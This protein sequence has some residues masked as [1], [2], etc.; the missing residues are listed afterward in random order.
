MTRVLVVDDEESVR[1]LLRVAFELAGFE[2]AEAPNGAAACE[3]ISSEPAPALVATDYMMPVMDGGELIQRL[4]TDPA[5]A[6]VPVMLISSSPGA[7]ERIGLADAFVQKPFDPTE[8]VAT[9][10]RLL[11]GGTG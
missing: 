5:T 8:V 9:A 6:S 2:V 10:E 4:R 3:L 1:F 7:R 11:E